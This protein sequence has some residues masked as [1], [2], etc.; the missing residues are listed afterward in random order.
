[1]VA[2][3]VPLLA[4]LGTTA[5]AATAATT[6][7]GAGIS[8]ALLAAPVAS[9]AG[10]SALSTGGILA[11]LGGLS[12]IMSLGSGLFSAY[13]TL[14]SGR[15]SS[16]AYKAESQ[17]LAMQAEFERTRAMQ[18]EANRAARLNEILGLQMAGQ[19]GRGTVMGSGTDIAISDFSE[20][21][22][23]RESDIANLDSKFQQSQLRAKAAQSRMS[24]RASLLSSR[25]QAAGTLFD[26]GVKF[27]ERR[28]T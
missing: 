17:Q 27:N 26:T 12:G 21:E 15:A 20:E 7:A 4:S 13:S 6:V 5:G 2:A 16:D 1:M 8:S 14:Q 19:A 23:R 25:Y 3:A 28:L 9:A 22:A 11:S 10:F 18:E 24:G